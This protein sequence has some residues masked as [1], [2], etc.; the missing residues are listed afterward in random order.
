M[1]QAAGK[2]GIKVM[3]LAIGIPVGIASRKAVQAIW[4]RTRGAETPR[5]PKEA[6]VQW[7]DAIIWAALSGA[8]VVVADLISRRTAEGA[9]RA[10][11]GNQ[12]P[13]KDA[14]PATA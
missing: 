2:V 3:T 10:L 7:G 8:G 6:G 11:T 4:D 1:A 12:P 14:Q 9:Y 13:V 5:K